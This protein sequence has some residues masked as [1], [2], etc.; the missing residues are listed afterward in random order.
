MHPTI[1]SFPNQAFYNSSLQDGTI[2][3]KG[4]VR[5]GLEPPKTSFLLDDE[6]GVKMNMTFV[7]HDTPESPL[8]SSLANYGDGEQVCNIVA[9]LLHNNPVSLTLFTENT[10]I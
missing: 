6:N 1:S 3:P 4:E 9:D 10:D 8:R 2:L 7:D 5:P